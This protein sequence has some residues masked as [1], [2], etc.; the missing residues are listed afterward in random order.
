MCACHIIAW[1]KGSRSHPATAPWQGRC[2]WHSVPVLQP[3][4]RPEEGARWQRCLGGAGLPPP[5]VAVALPPPHILWITR[6][7][8]GSP[9]PV[10]WKG[11]FSCRFLRFQYKSPHLCLWLGQSTAS[12][13]SAKLAASWVFHTFLHDKSYY[14]NGGCC[15]AKDFFNLLCSLARVYYIK[16][17]SHLK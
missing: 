8:Q 12:L 15:W 5:Q 6:R 4:E 11:G 14:F 3:Q 2:G 16:S 1:G 17:N 9:G 13:H 10:K 7:S